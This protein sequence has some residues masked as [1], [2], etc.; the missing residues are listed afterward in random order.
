M[1]AET[2]FCHLEPITFTGELRKSP[3]FLFSVSSCLEL[4]QQ[5][6]IQLCDMRHKNL[7][8]S[9]IH[10]VLGV[11]L[12]PNLTGKPSICRD[13]AVWSKEYHNRVVH[14]D[15]EECSEALLCQQSC[16]I[17]NQ[18][19]AYKTPSRAPIIGRTFPCMEADYPYTI[20]NQR[21]ASKKPLVGGFLRSKAPSRGLWMRGAGSLWHKRH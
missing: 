11:D 3:P 14:I 1:L 6:I 4:K 16:A 20:K 21:G 10:C 19:V 2:R 9:D 12:T 15:V 17:K 18:F 8:L 5:N 7:Y 13:E